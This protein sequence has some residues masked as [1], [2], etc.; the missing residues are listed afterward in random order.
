MEIST[1]KEFNTIKQDLISLQEELKSKVLQYDN[2][3]NDDSLN[4]GISIEVQKID[5]QINNLNSGVF[6]IMIVGEF[7]TGKSTFINYL[8]DEKVLP[9]AI[10]PT[11]ATINL[12]KYGSEKKVFVH[13]FEDSNSVTR[14]KPIEIPI[15]ELSK[16]S[17]SLNDDSNQVSK[18]IKL[19]EVLYPNKYCKNG[20]EILDTPGLNSVYEHHERAT[21]EYLPNGNCGIMLFNAGQF[22]TK[23][24]SDYLKIFKKYLNKMFFVVNKV[25]LVDQDEL[26]DT[27]PFWKDQLKQILGD[28]SEIRLYPVSAKSVNDSENGAAMMKEFLNDFEAF[29]ISDEK[30]KEIIFPPIMN[31]RNEIRGILEEV[32]LKYE[33]L[34]FSPTEFEEKLKNNIPKLDRAKRRKTELEKFIYERSRYLAEKIKNEYELVS[35]NIS[36]EVKESIIGWE[37]DLAK[38]KEELPQIIKQKSTSLV[39]EFQTK[40]EREL[41]EL[42]KDISSRVRDLHEELVEFKTSIVAEESDITHAMIKLKDANV[43]EEMDFYDLAIQFGG[44]FGIGWIAGAVLGGPIGWAAAVVGN[45]VFSLFNQEKKRVKELSEIANK[46]TS[47]LNENFLNLYPEIENKFKKNMHIIMHNTSELFTKMIMDVENTIQEIK[48]EMEKERYNIENKRN[49][50]H[51]IKNDFLDIDQKLIKIA[52][53]V[54]NTNES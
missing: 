50:Y 33:S 17:T 2:I 54:G 13:Y 23:S 22:L 42:S 47:K 31:S 11:T 20:V 51:K 39:F 12:I 24:E 8:L 43:S 53:I 41:S 18:N 49:E 44:Y 48:L 29:L 26:K 3:L 1:L 6:K 32:A 14:G 38:L 35:R 46:I 4:K 34:K 30:A 40:I 27:L 25:D 45:I 9:T 52:N 5:R 7:S 15:E 10:K 28:A 16:Y 19:V 36:D 21:N 37:S